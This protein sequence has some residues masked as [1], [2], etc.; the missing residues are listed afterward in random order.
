MQFMFWEAFLSTSNSILCEREFEVHF[1]IFQII[2][3]SGTGEN[4]GIGCFG[5]SMY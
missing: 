4:C 3:E 5:F 1:I 2:Q